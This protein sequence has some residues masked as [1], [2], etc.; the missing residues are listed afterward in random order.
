MKAYQAL[1]QAYEAFK[2]SKD[3]LN[4]TRRASAEIGRLYNFAIWSIDQPAQ[5]FKKAEAE[6][7]ALKVC[8][9]EAF[10]AEEACKAAYI[11]V[12]RLYTLAYDKYYS[13]DHSIVAKRSQPAAY[14]KAKEAFKIALKQAFQPFN[15][16][17]YNP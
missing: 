8:R 6:V 4:K 7:H 2:K 13:L 14:Y 9:N 3:A 17:T 10:Q 15:Q 1:N 5:T 11:E 16:K 12:C